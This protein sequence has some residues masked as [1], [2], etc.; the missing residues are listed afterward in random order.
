MEQI[1]VTTLIMIVAGFVILYGAIKGKNPL[2][3]VQKAL[4]GKPPS[5]AASL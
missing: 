3:I 4:Q 1:N 5:E 2:S